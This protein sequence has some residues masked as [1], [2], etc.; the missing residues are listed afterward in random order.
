MELA[1]SRCATC[2]YCESRGYVV[3]VAAV[4]VCVVHVA[5]T[6][7]AAAVV[8][9]FL[10]IVGVLLDVIDGPPRFGRDARAFCGSGP[11][12]GECGPSVA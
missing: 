8:A 12:G 4:R 7:E 6:V 10:V 1:A 11:A 5:P 2:L 9:V 3:V